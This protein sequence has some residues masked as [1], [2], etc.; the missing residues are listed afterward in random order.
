MFLSR[1]LLDCPLFSGDPVES[2]SV[3]SAQHRCARISICPN[4]RPFSSRVSGYCRFRRCPRAPSVRVKRATR[5]TPRHTLDVSDQDSAGTARRRTTSEAFRCAESPAARHGQ[6]VPQALAA[7]F[8]DG[9]NTAV[10]LAFLPLRLRTHQPRRRVSSG[11]DRS[12]RSLI[13]EMAHR[14][15]I[16]RPRS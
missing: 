12:G 8:R 13:P 16:D 6:P 9:V 10:R 15:R 11:W 2:A 5:D 3:S 1:R 7:L 4:A 14:P